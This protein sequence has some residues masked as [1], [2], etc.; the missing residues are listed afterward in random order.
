MN[1]IQYRKV[2]LVVGDNEIKVYNKEN[3]ELIHIL[4]HMTNETMQ[5]HIYCITELLASIGVKFTLDD[6]YF[7]EK[8]GLRLVPAIRIN[9]SN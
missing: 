4:R 9:E 1:R 6:N 7:Y 3:M 8:Y 5:E 2:K